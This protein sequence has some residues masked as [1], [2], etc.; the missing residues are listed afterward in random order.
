M[1]EIIKRRND[2]T[3]LFQ[4]TWDLNHGYGYHIQIYWKKHCK[5]LNKMIH[6]D[7]TYG[8]SKNKFTAVRMA[9][10]EKSLTD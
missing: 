5:W 6:D 3:I 7:I 10:K 4:K 8:F 2:H 1:S 9:L